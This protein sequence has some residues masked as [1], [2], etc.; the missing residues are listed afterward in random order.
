MAALSFVCAKAYDFSEGGIFYTKTSATTVSVTSGDSKYTG[1]IS[2]PATVTYDG[3]TYNVTEIGNGAFVDNTAV[4]SVSLPACIT[5]IGN[6]SFN[7]C[8][9]MTSF[10]VEA[11]GTLTSIGQQAFDGCSALTTLILPSTV[12]YLGAGCFEDCASLSSFKLPESLETLNSSVFKGCTSL[13]AIELPAGLKVIGNGAFSNCSLNK[14]VL[15]Q[16]LEKVDNSSFSNNAGLKSINFP[17]SVT[18]IG[19]DAFYGDTNIDTI[20]AEWPDPSSVSVGAYVF[21]GIYAT[22]QL[23]VPKGKVDTYRN[24]IWQVFKY[25]V[26]EGTTGVQGVAT[27]KAVA[28]VK[29]FNLNGAENSQ[30]FRG[31]N[32]EKVTFTDGTTTSVKVMK[33]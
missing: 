21:Y 26:E 29:Y 25:I 6:G 22:C 2:V 14:V 16:G 9:A 15:P 20:R 11:N 31:V 3:T 1:D 27:D 18:Y 8:S 13:S 23:I 32:V 7:R 5:K 28:S 24:S 19:Q 12:S 4:T 10:T 33:Q 17:A 30:P